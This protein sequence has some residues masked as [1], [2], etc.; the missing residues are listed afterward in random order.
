MLKYR[1][2]L[3]IST[4]GTSLLTNGAEPSLAKLLRDSANWRQQDF[5]AAQRQ[6]VDSRIATVRA[7]LLQSNISAIREMSAEFNGLLGY[8]EDRLDGRS[9]DR[10]CLL[11]TAT[12]QGEAVA[13]ILERCLRSHNLNVS[14]QT[15]PD[16]RTDAI[17][18]FHNGITE[19]IKW[20]EDTLPGYRNHQYHIVFNLTGGFKGIQGWMQTLGMFYADEIVYIF[21]GSQLLR[22]PRVPVAIDQGARQTVERHL[23]TFRRLAVPG[24]TCHAKDVRDIPEIFFHF[25]DN[26]VWLSPWGQLVWERS[27]RD[28]YAVRLHDSPSTQIRSA[29]K[30]RNVA[31]TLPK[32]RLIQVNERMDDLALY[33]SDGK[34]NLNRLDFKKLKGNPR[35]P[36]THECDAWADR[37]A[38][39][40]F[41]HFEGETLI[42]DDLDAGLHS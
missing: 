27:R 23:E 22:I 10:H 35:P 3:M 42:L 12:Y 19:L 41:A 25:L 38:W 29:E 7:K 30:F 5:D 16:L 17:E 20:C 39:R 6:A 1:P 11:H 9:Q 2:T 8:Y 24:A 31:S 28:I 14:R 34:Q 40:I 18:N 15:F 26:Q 21:E 4:C 13:E 37:S 33:L 36:S 32:D